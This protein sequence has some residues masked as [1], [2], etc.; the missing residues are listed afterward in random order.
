MNAA[1]QGNIPEYMANVEPINELDNVAHVETRLHELSDT[2]NSTT[3]E[4]LNNSSCF[5]W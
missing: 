2:I 4:I 5:N 1:S 3:T